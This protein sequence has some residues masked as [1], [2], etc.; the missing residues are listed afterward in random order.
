MSSQNPW[1]V[2]VDVEPTQ[3]PYQEVAQKFPELAPQENQ[4]N[5]PEWATLKS[6]PESGFEE[7]ERVGCQ[8]TR[9]GLESLYGIPGGIEKFGR[10]LRNVAPH[11]LP[12]MD[13]D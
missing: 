4:Q 2:L 5:Q 8:M 11:K 3:Q 13:K 1:D 6:A 7:A 9:R 10:T 12:Y